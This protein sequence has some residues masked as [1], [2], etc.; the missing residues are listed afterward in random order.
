MSDS[1]KKL[2]LILTTMML[3]EYFGLPGRVQAAES[4]I[5][6]QEQRSASE[7]QSREGLIRIKERSIQP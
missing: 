1:L 4:L 6:A 7:N 3:I 2:I 5:F